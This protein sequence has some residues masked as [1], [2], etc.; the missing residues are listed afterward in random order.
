MVDDPERPLECPLVH[1]EDFTPCDA[2]ELEPL[3]DFLRVGAPVTQRTDFPRGTLLPDGRLDLCKQD[4]GPEGAG[5]VLEALTGYAH[6]SSLLLGTNGIGNPGAQAV[7][8]LLER[9]AR[10]STVYLGCNLIDARGARV[11]AGAVRESRGV[12]GLWLKRNPIGPEA[13]GIISGLLPG[14]A[15]LR[16]LD[17]V[18]T[19]LD[20]EGLRRL[21]EGLLEHG[22]GIEFLFLSGNRIDA[23]GTRWLAELLRR[24]T[25]LR[26]LYLSVNPLGDEGVGLL[27]GALAENQTLQALGLGST[28]LGPEGTGALARV[29]RTHPSLQVLSLSRAPSEKTLGAPANRLGEEGVAALVALLEENPVLRRLDVRRAGVSDA[30]AWRLLTAAGRRAVRLDIQLEGRLPENL[31]E[32][33]RLHARTLPPEEEALSQRAIR[34]VSR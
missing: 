31:R 23:S 34:S 16:T 15:R 22:P 12:E 27:A 14:N 33:L 24:H 25:G 9:N 26:G 28:G 20:A 7:A 11:L 10:V 17:L 19:G 5:R 8:R 4:L 13:G 3:I 6:V 32:A 1:R 21:V 29:L 18:H 30:G 2:R